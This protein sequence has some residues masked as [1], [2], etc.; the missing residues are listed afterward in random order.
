[1]GTLLGNICTNDMTSYSLTSK[2]LIR[3]LILQE[4]L[5]HLVSQD[6]HL[7]VKFYE[8]GRG[9]EGKS[10]QMSFFVK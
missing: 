4:A 3:H 2:T 9:G 7:D 6:A 5:A 8:V 1:M 10:P